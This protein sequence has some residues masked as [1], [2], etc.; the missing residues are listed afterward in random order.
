MSQKMANNNKCT[1]GAHSIARVCQNL[2]NCRSNI[3]AH[4]RR[5]KLRFFYLKDFGLENDLKFLT[6]VKIHKIFLPEMRLNWHTQN[7]N[8]L[9]E[10]ANKMFKKDKFDNK[11]AG[12]LLLDKTNLYCGQ[13]LFA[14]S[15]KVHVLLQSFTFLYVASP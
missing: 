9:G 15:L 6:N 13:T 14:M 10:N 3:S 4:R 7:V 5:R 2:V 8:F 11:S 12:I 1:V